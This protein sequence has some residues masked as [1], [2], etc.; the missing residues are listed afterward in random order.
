MR[1]LH[2]IPLACLSVATLLSAC[3]SHNGYYDANGNYIPQANTTTEAQRT[4][5]PYPGG[6]RNSSYYYAPVAAP[7]ASTTTYVDTTP[8]RDGVRRTTTTVYSY[9]RAGYYDYN[10]YYVTP[11]AALAPAAAFPGH[12]LCRVW[13]PGRAVEAQPPI[14]SCGNI[15]AR[16]PAGAYVIYGG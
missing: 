2:L 16:V 1:K 8:E 3:E 13:F 4:H 12:G 6:E 11:P 10:G 7:A 9:D 15:N 14:E 5:A